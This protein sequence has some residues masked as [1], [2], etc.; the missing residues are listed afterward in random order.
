[1]EGI[2]FALN[3][4]ADIWERETALRARDA[5]AQV[6]LVLNASP[7]A[8]DKQESR[9]HV[10]RERIAETG[11]AVVYANLVVGHDVFIFDGGSFAMY[12]NVVL[13]AQCAVF[14]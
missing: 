10:I 8:I 4:C 9:H 13:T 5:G 11:M 2:R 14:E 12:R 1:M 3:I 7:Y 6:L